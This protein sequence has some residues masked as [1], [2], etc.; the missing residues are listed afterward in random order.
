MKRF[1]VERKIRG[2]Q[3][4]PQRL[5]AF[6]TVASRVHA[7]THS[8]SIRVILHNGKMN[9]RVSNVMEW[10]TCDDYVYKLQRQILSMYFRLKPELLLRIRYYRYQIPEKNSQLLQGLFFTCLSQG[11]ELY[12]CHYIS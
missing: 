8:L 12:F 9:A 11:W 5:Q 6:L 3:V 1:S 2:M 4:S 10:R 7:E